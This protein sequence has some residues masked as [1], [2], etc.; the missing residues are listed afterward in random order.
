MTRWL[1]RCFFLFATFGI[2]NILVAQSSLI[3]S[4]ITVDSLKRLVYFLASDSLK[5]RLTGSAYAEQAASF[6]AEEFKNAGLQSI[7]GNKGYY[8]TFTFFGKTALNVMATLP[9]SSKSKELIIFSAHYDHIGM[10]SNFRSI[11][12]IKTKQGKTDSIYNGANDNA[13][14]VSAIICLARYFGQLKNNERTIIFIAFSG[15]E[16]ELRGSKSLAQSINANN[17][18]AMINIDMIGRERSEK[19]TNPYITGGR[20]SD[21]KDILNRQLNETAP[22]IYGSKF[23]EKDP[24]FME[25]LLFRSD[26]YWFATRGIPAHTII[27]SS[28]TDPYYHSLNDEPDKLNYSLMARLIKAIALASTGLI[29]GSVTPSR[30]NKDHIPAD[31]S[32]TY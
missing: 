13:S 6:I 5:G 26:S 3:D 23:F 31:R 17:V 9:G 18:I 19:H 24:Y 32:A 28:P 10:R 4:V 20:L 21:L 1:N 12:P 2:T 25:G 11:L 16:E 22:K 30:I 27:A 8:N 14:G 15:E 29:N 7:A